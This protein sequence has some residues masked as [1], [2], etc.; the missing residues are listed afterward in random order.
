[1]ADTKPG[2]PQA[3]TEQPAGGHGGGFPP[4]NAETFPSQLL[5]FVLAFGA[6]YL[7][8]S[9][10]ALP[11]V[12]AVL[13][14]RQNKITGDL[15]L[16]AAAQKQADDASKA[17]DKTVADARARAQAMGQEAAA[18]AAAETDARRK[19]I[20]NELNVKLAAAEAQI[21]AA[22][23][24][25]MANVDQIAR[26]TAASIVQRLTGVAPAAD[27]IASAVASAKNS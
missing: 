19:T 18:K 23:T 21:S 3:H 2:A 10:V 24:A 4:F 1:M 22:K 14:H 20:E 6:L 26:D 13:D 8:M 16:A 5:W 12:G 25:A 27:A 9:K 7:L 17:Y 15:D 11:R